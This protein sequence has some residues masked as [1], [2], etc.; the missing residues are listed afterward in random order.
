MLDQ[1]KLYNIYVNINSILIDDEIVGYRITCMNVPSSHISQHPWY[2]IK[3]SHRYLYPIMILDGGEWL[4]YCNIIA[5][6]SQFLS[7]SFS[8]I[9][10]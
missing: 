5:S 8:F 6:N 2:M 9:F 1:K 10:F 3:T 4:M 7:L